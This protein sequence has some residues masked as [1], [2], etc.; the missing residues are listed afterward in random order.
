VDQNEYKRRQAPP[1]L[2]VTEKAF[3]VGRRIPIVKKWDRAVGEALASED[4]VSRP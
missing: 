2:R 3:G 4:P 1:G